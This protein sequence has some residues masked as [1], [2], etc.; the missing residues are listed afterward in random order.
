MRRESD[1][2]KP[3]FA[4]NP[5]ARD[6]MEDG[7]VMYG[8]LYSHWRSQFRMRNHRPVQGYKTMDRKELA[9]MDFE[10]FLK[11]I[12]EPAISGGSNN[13]LKIT[14]PSEMTD[15][16]GI[17]RQRISV[18]IYDMH[19]PLA[20]WIFYWYFFQ[21]SGV[22]IPNGGFFPINIAAQITD[23]NDQNPYYTESNGDYY[24][25]VFIAYDKTIRKPPR[26]F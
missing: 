3:Y 26:V 22:T 23:E 8:Y 16:V 19:Q 5:V 11:K 21:V 12:G 1:P 18:N 6:A 24:W 13:K 15:I 25:K 2:G 17:V 20:L 7:F 4:R 14:L 9:P 10:C